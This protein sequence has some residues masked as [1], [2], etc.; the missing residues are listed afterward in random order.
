LG[1]TGFNEV[2]GYIFGDWAAEAFSYKPQGLPNFAGY[3]MGYH[4]VQ[5]Y[6]RE[7]GR[8]AAQA[9]YVPW[10]AIVEES[11]LFKTTG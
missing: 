6:L 5:S 10:Q 1:I 11:R 4:L 9:T 8:T 7:S 3:A 2:R